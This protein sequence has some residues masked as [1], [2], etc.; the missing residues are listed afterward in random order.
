MLIDGRNRAVELKFT[1]PLRMLNMVLLAVCTVFFPYILAFL[2]NGFSFRGFTM[3]GGAVWLCIMVPLAPVF[4]I[5]YGRLELYEH[6]IVRYRTDD[7]RRRRYRP[8]SNARKEWLDTVK[9]FVFS[10]FILVILFLLLVL[11]VSV[12]LVLHWDAF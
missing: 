2:F 11:I 12:V 1:T 4:L 3:G 10:P 5:K 8:A 7:G 9:V 6:P